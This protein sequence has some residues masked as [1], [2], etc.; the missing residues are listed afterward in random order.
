MNYLT[1]ATTAICDAI[2]FL[3]KQNISF[4]KPLLASYADGSNLCKIGKIANGKFWTTEGDILDIMEIAPLQICSIAD[5][6]YN[7]KQS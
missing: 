2:F 1:R 7:Y 6:V 5:I 4:E 3:K